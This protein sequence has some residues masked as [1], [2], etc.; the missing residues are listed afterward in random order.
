MHRNSDS[1]PIIIDKFHEEAMDEHP[2]HFGKS[3]KK[4]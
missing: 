2:H 4:R 3:T 1:H